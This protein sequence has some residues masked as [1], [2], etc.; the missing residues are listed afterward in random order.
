MRDCI[1][2]VT[3]LL[4]GGAEGA[5]QR[6]MRNSFLVSAGE[7]AAPRWPR[8]SGGA[9]PCACV[10]TMPLTVKPPYPP[11][12]RP[13]PPRLLSSREAPCFR[14]SVHLASPHPA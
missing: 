1:T 3:Q 13:A 14:T 11:V 10:R 2:R 8:R 6:A 9:A 12:T 7:A 4:A 5:V